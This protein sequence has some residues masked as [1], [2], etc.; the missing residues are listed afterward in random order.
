M[1]DSRDLL[2][3]RFKSRMKLSCGPFKPRFW[4]LDPTDRGLTCPD[5]IN[6]QLFTGINGIHSDIVNERITVKSWSQP[7]M[8]AHMGYLQP[9]IARYLEL[10]IRR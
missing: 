4:S 6:G 3:K 1:G 5:C 8:R 2:A 7:S 10:D 9:N